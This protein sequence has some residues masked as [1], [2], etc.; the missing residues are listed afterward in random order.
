MRCLTVRQPM[1]WAI[2]HSTKDV[3]NRPKSL[4]PYRGLV[5]IHAGSRYE[6]SYFDEVTRLAGEVPPEPG[7]PRSPMLFGYV[8][9]I[10]QLVGAHRAGECGGRCSVWAHPTGWHYR[11]GF[12]RPLPHPIPADGRLGLWRPDTELRARIVAQLAP[13]EL[14]LLEPEG[15]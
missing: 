3:D 9:G 8:T 4:G 12:R 13:P 11:L 15:A 10:S 7:M 14:R 1:A 5:P 2:T 6:A